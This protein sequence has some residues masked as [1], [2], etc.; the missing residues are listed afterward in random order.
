[1][2]AGERWLL[3]EGKHSSTTAAGCEKGSRHNNPSASNVAAFPPHN[4]EHQAI[5]VMVY[6]LF[7]LDSFLPKYSPATT[8]L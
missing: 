8:G 1:M 3:R 2:A 4:T 7:E 6:N 5:I